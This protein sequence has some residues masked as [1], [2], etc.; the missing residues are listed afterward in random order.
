MRAVQIGPVIGLT[1]LLALLAALAG[2]VGLGAAGWATG[3][4]CGVI[5]SVVL[6]RALAQHGVAEL[7]PADRVTLTRAVLVG[8]VAA[9]TADSFGGAV[10]VPALVALAAVAL[11][12][13][14]VDGWVAR[15]TAT[16]S[17]L[18]ARFDMDVDA[19]L[20][21]VLS[22]YVARSLG[23][24]VLLIGLARYGFVAAGWRL[25]WLRAPAPPRYWCKVVAATQGV[26][27]TVVAAGIAPRYLSVAAVAVSLV[28]L[29]E[30]F[31]REAWGK[32]RCRSVRPGPIVVTL[33]GEQVRAG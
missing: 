16:S 10:S 8:G 30:S 19:F 3:A 17:T 20:I 27:L 1:A 15:R 6:A 32:W 25:A 11:V 28:M 33:L 9:L 13:D 21:L 18:G 5:A 24:W 22:G 12:L 2:T 29:A 23:A 4:G 26:V 7:G 14:G 31:G